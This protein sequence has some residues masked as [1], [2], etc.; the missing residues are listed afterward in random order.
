[1]IKIISSKKSANQKF[2]SLFFRNRN[3]LALLG[4][5]LF[6]FSASQVRA[7]TFTVANFDDSGPGSLRQA[8]IDANNMPNSPVNTPDNIVIPSTFSDGTIKL[9]TPLPAITDSVTITSQTTNTRTELNGLATQNGATPSIGFDIQAPNCRITGFVINRFGDA[10]IR[11]G[12][13]AAGTSSGDGTIIGQ[14]YIG[15]AVNGTSTNCPDDAEV[16]HPCGN[17]NRGVWVDGAS[18]VQ[19]GIG[20]FNNQQANTI[21]GN[22]GRGISVNS[23]TM[24]GMTFAGSAI[25]QN[26]HIGGTDSFNSPT[27]SIGNSQDGILLAGVSG[28]QIG[29]VNPLEGNTIIG[30]GGSGISIIAD[31]NSPA[32]NNVVQ[33][34]NIGY[35]GGSDRA[36]GN[37]GSGIVIQ[38]ASNII[39]GTTPEAR[40][41]IV[42]NK[43]NGISINSSL[44]TGN[45]V[46]GNYI[47]ISPNNSSFGNNSN[48][49]QISN[50]ASGNTIGGTTGATL[51][52]TPACTGA[53]N[54]IA[55]N[56]VDTTAQT[57]KAGLY[58]DPTAG[59]GN[60]IRANYIYNNGGATGIGIDLGTP[61]KNTDDAGDADSGPN[62]LQNAPVLNNAYQTGFVKGMLNS[63][64][65]TNFGID[66]YR[67]DTPD[68]AADSEGRTYIGSINVTTDGS[69]NATISFTS[70][71]TLTAGQFVTATATVLPGSAFSAPQASVVGDTSEI[72]AAVI[73]Q[74]GGP[75]AAAATISGQVVNGNGVGLEG[76][77]VRVLDTASGQ[78]FYAATDGK[79]N[80]RFE[81]LPV[82]QNYIITPVSIGYSFNPSSKFV[83][84]VEDLTVTT[85]T[86]TR[87]R[88]FGR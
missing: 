40:N 15:T 38:G 19:I 59:N 80:Y 26:N 31:V 47:G 32:S 39:G 24:G 44:A 85:F 30:N 2:F 49:V 20:T 88:R 64:P 50:F 62:N 21:S 9:M 34:N 60:A 55:N 46:Q 82:G 83:S 67:N 65:N 43:V 71:V 70:A 36:V 73:V 13:N 8:I 74:P 84:L 79:G 78:T 11:V 41:V 33:G 7:A 52:A 14:N 63:T 81:N 18:S 37:N 16:A 35:T 3:F 61:G 10:G 23:K 6:A 12:P 29:G 77:S 17:I 86:A 76:I 51:G 66:F 4:I 53:C 45:I 42:G 72:S 28:C 48:G 69:G 5:V 58:L 68:T 54:V 1:M 87:K 56:G 25:I 75:T 57:A 22:F 27:I